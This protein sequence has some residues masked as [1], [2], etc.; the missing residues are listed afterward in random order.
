MSLRLSG[1]NA[2]VNRRASGILLWRAG[3]QASTLLL[4]SNQ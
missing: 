2:L 4:I 1:I 3:F